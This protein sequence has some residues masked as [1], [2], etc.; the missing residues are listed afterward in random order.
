MPSQDFIFERNARW[1][2]RRFVKID[3]QSNYRDEDIYAGG[4]M[5]VGGG[6]GWENRVEFKIIGSLS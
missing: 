5:G 6:V 4:N 3:V 1:G 2:Q